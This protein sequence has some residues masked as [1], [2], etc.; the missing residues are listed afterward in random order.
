MYGK[1]FGLE[2]L[3]QNCTEIAIKV[4][5]AVTWVIEMEKAFIYISENASRNQIEKC[6]EKLKLANAEGRVGIYMYVQELDGSVILTEDEELVNAETAIENLL[7]EFGD[8]VEKIDS[9][10]SNR[11]LTKIK[12]GNEPEF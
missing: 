2:K 4:F 6:I 3:T 9:L 7:E 10:D 12:E 11:R 5:N 1:I 8:R